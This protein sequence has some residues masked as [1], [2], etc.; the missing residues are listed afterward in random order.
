MT[1]KEM[2]PVPVVFHGI[3]SL[4]LSHKGHY[5][6][7]LKVKNKS[8]RGLLRITSAPPCFN[9]ILRP[10]RRAR[11]LRVGIFYLAAPDTRY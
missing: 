10:A 1:V 4:L 8:S 3:G 5:D 2:E 6:K 7:F 11:I 9:L